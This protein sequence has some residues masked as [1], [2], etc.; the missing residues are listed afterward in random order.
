LFKSLF[1][2]LA[3]VLLLL[4][5]GLLYYPK[6]KLAHTEATISWDVSGYYYYLPAFLIYDDARKLDW[7]DD[8]LQRYHPAPGDQAYTHSGGNMVMKYS[9]GLALQYLPFFLVA[10]MIA[11]LI[12]YPADGFSKPYQLAIS[13]G[14][15]LMACFGLWILRSVLRKYF[16]DGVVALALVTIAFATN[17]TD[18]AAINHAMTHNYLFTWYAVLIL[19]SDLYWKKQKLS[20]ALLIGSVTG[21]MVL[22]RPSEVIAILLPLLWGLDSTSGIAARFRHFLRNWS[23]LI[24]AGGAFIFL[25]MIQVAYWKY[26]TGDWIVYSYQDQGF[27]WLSPHIINGM[28]SYR[29]GWLVYTPVMAGAL[30]GFFYLLKKSKAL[31]YPF[32]VLSVIFMYVTWAWDIWWYGGSLGQRSMVQLYPVLAFPL[33]TLIER[34]LRSKITIITGGVILSV[35]IYYNLWLTHQAHK[36]GLLRAG[37]M[38]KAYFWKILGRYRVEEEAQLLLDN[39]EWYDGASAGKIIFKEDFENNDSL[40]TCLVPVISG[41]QS[42]CLGPSSEFSSMMKFEVPPG[43]RW[44]RATARFR[45]THKEWDV[46]KMAQ[47]RLH[48]FKGDTAVKT[49]LIRVFRV[50]DDNEMQTFFLD[51]HIPRHL[52]FDQG[53]VDL[54][55]AVSEKYIAVDDLTVE[56]F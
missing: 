47:F 33:A 32:L 2:Y 19:L 5:G 15:L 1:A 12:S 56:A 44:L 6:W 7:H 28:F 26:A 10:D 24:A 21:I 42:C 4:A 41:N 39:D 22:T 31:F 51:L 8:I 11:P 27:S 13:L 16:Q 52:D 43:T 34:I 50:L 38:T 35:C 23:H 3:C 48:L 46:Y 53:G 54:W 55:N 25:G 30:I 45:C 36:G 37:D 49:N 18:Y 20:N 17:Y 29:A 9:I 40:F 14:S